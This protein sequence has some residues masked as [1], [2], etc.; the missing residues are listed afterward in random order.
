MVPSISTDSGMMLVRTPPLIFPIDI[1]AGACV[2]ST[3]RLTIVCRP[4]TIWDATTIGSTPAQGMPPWV[5]FPVTVM[6]KVLPAA[7]CP[8]A[9]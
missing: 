2:R 5:C 4:S 8:P 1:T 6:D 3:W 7:I 9:R